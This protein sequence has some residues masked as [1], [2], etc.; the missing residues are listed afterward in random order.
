MI[1]YYNRHNRLASACPLSNLSPIFGP[2]IKRKIERREAVTQQREERVISSCLALETRIYQQNFAMLYCVQIKLSFIQ[3][4]TLI[5]EGITTNK[6]SLRRFSSHRQDS[7]YVY[8]N[9]AYSRVL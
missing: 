3:T 9:F 4:T 1:E 7:S 8:F 5:A 6:A 2:S